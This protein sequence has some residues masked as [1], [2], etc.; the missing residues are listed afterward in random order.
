[1][2]IKRLDIIETLGSTTV[3]ASDKTGTLTQNLMSVASMWVLDG[4]TERFDSEIS[5]GQLTELSQAEWPRPLLTVAYVCNAA[6]FE[7]S[8]ILTEVSVRVGGA[9][10][11]TRH[12]AAEERRITGDASDI[13]LFRF[14]HA[15][16]GMNELRERHHTL[17]TIPFNSASKWMLTVA[18][19]NQETTRVDGAQRHHIVLLKGAPEIVLSKCS[20]YQSARGVRALDDT[21]HDTVRTAIFH[22][23]SMGERVLAFAHRHL[24][25][26]ETADVYTETAEEASATPGGAA[27]AVPTAGFTFLGLMSLADPPRPNV[28]TAVG[29]LKGA[30]IRVFMVTGDHPVTG[31]AIARK[32]GI[33]YEGRTVVEIARQRGCS[34]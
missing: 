25:G 31:E 24:V 6:R 32:V 3:V 1:M 7:E 10:P 30:G 16:P 20:T 26:D 2:Y 17:F 8:G 29:T 21:A 22:A 15:V 18:H 14:C 27:K 13:A 33:I 12:E 28:A 34:V 9:N 19:D 11:L 4:M 5:V 23:A